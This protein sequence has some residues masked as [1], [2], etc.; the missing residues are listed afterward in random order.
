[1]NL[2]WSS[3]VVLRGV[4]VDRAVCG[5]RLEESAVPTLFFLGEERRLADG[6]S[7][8]GISSGRVYAVALK[9]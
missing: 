7:G 9:R 3:L 6:V 8:R 1:M 5:R 2:V 4:R